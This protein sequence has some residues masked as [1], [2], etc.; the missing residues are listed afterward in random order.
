MGVVFVFLH[1]SYKSFDVQSEMSPCLTINWT[2]ETMKCY[3]NDLSI[4]SM[5]YKVICKVIFISRIVITIITE[6]TSR[7]LFVNE[8]CTLCVQFKISNP[9]VDKLSRS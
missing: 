7:V 3:P 4:N 8:L 5:F 2:D 9:Q 1:D 6:R